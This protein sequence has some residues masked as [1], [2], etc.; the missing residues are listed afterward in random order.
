[1]EFKINVEYTGIEGKGNIKSTEES[2]IMQKV[3][4]AVSAAIEQYN[5]ENPDIN[6]KTSLT[7]Q[8]EEKHPE[9]EQLSSRE[10][11]KFVAYAKGQGTKMPFDT[12]EMGILAAGRKD[13]QN[14]LAEIMNS[15]EFGKP[16]CMECDEKMENRGRSKKKL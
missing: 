5:A 9:L 16:A 12:M 10:V 11:E 14:G 8:T 6:V 1:M 13:M 7:Q 2:A 3:N 15:I 4:E